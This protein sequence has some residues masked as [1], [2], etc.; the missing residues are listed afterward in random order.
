MSVKFKSK[1]ENLKIG[2]IWKTVTNLLIYEF[3]FLFYIKKSQF[4]Y[5][6]PEWTKT[7]FPE[8]L[9]TVVKQNIILPTYTLALKRL[10]AG[11]NNL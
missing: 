7:I 1:L 3:L 11:I 2:K 8:P 10:R 4:N 5:T 9:L 6:L